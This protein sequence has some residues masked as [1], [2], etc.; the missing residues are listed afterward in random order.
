MLIMKKIKALLILL[1]FFWG[2]SI[3]VV[4]AEVDPLFNIDNDNL[5]IKPNKILAKIEDSK[6]DNTANSEAFVLFNNKFVNNT[7]EAADTFLPGGINT[8][9]H[10]IIK[11]EVSET[12][13][14]YSNILLE[15]EDASNND[16]ED[17]N[18]SLVSRNPCNSIAPLIFKE[19]TDS[20][21][22]NRMKTVYFL[23]SISTM[24]GQSRN[25]QDGF[26]KG[27]KLDGGG[28]SKGEEYGYE[29]VVRNLWNPVGRAYK[30]AKVDNSGS[31]VNFFLHPFFGFGISSYLTTAGASAKEVFAVAEADNFL[32]EYVIEGTYVAPSGIDLLATTGGCVIGYFTSKYIFK[33]PFKAFVKTTTKIKKRFNVEFDPIIE[34]GYIGRGMKIGSQITFKR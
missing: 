9:E 8:D 31:F 26:T 32:F 33:K 34:P 11:G 12:T 6:K 23:T 25:I 30:G 16:L 18:F 14:L 22:I 24:M 5:T 29:S 2:M 15:P 19:K 17:L 7:Y 10:K 1:L 20:A 28:I 4:N 21:L 27:K 13:E 3:N